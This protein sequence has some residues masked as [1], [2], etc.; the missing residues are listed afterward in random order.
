MIVDLYLVYI[1]AYGMG[2]GVLGF[3]LKS[4]ERK[5]RARASLAKQQRQQA[6]TTPIV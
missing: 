3:W 1:A 5:K 6:E 2:L 4:R